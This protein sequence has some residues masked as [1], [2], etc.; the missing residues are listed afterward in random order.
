MDNIIVFAE[1]G[2]G[3]GETERQRDILLQRVEARER[4]RRLRRIL[5]RAGSAAAVL[6]LGLGLLWTVRHR[7]DSVQAGLG[8]KVQKALPDGSVVILNSDSRL[9]YARDLGR[10]QRRDVWMEGEAFFKVAKDLGGK[11]FV[12]HAGHFDVEVTGTQ[13]NLRSGSDGSS[14]LLTE[15]SVTLRMADGGTRRMLP[16]DYFAVSDEEGA[17]PA[18]PAAAMRGVDRPK[19]ADVLSWLDRSLVFENTPLS[20]VAREIGV[21][22]KVAVV[23]ATD[24][25]GGLTVTGILP[26]DNLEILLKSLEA[27]VDVRVRRDGDTLRIE[28]AP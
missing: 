2:P 7:R 17:A 26:N 18:G 19:P 12:V 6:A 24:R 14:I 16:G 22:Y 15:G 27:T 4:A 3:P 28:D 5:W 9:R 21:R 23:A 11:P 25:I 10:R 13:F 1:R 20:E 8:E